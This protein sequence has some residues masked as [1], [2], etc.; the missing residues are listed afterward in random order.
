MNNKIKLIKNVTSIFVLLIFL[1]FSLFYFT[2]C[3]DDP[4]SAEIDVNSMSDKAIVPIYDALLVSYGLHQN[5]TN[6]DNLKELDTYENVGQIKTSAIN[7]LPTAR[8]SDTNFQSTV[9]ENCYSMLNQIVYLLENDLIY[10]TKENFQLVNLKEND[11]YV[12]EYYV[13]FIVLENSVEIDIVINYDKENEDKHKILIKYDY[14]N[15][16]VD[17]MYIDTYK[18]SQNGDSIKCSMLGSSFYSYDVDINSQYGKDLITN[19]SKMDEEIKDVKSDMII[20]KE[21]IFGDN[22]KNCKIINTT[23]SKMAQ[24]AC[25]YA[26]Y[27]ME[28]KTG[29]DQSSNLNSSLFGITLDTSDKNKSSYTSCSITEIPEDISGTI[30]NWAGEI[31]Y[32]ATELSKAQITEVCN[33]FYSFTHNDFTFLVNI[34]IENGKSVFCKLFK[35]KKVYAS[36]EYSDVYDKCF[37]K[38]EYD[39]EDDETTQDRKLESIIIL[40]SENLVENDAVNWNTNICIY[41]GTQ[42]FYKTCENVGYGNDEDLKNVNGFL[43]NQTPTT[44]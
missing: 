29:R 19:F 28:N 23:T 7:S 11:N 15:I 13:K 18:I 43:S 26:G 1:S 25:Y 44:D 6:G 38:I 40:S 36:G 20:F 4:T 31:S 30:E 22:V 16:C 41:H 24:L 34:Q 10:V 8:S 39:F 33:G 42:F 21:N 32:L 35:S 2:A 27:F 3:N 14:E 5:K 37:F 9:K 17:Q 12:G